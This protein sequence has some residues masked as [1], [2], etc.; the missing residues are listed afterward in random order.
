[1]FHSYLE[2]LKG[3]FAGRE[4][5]ITEENLQARIRGNYLMALSNKFGWLV[6]TT[7]NKSEMATGYATLY[8][9]M[10]G[11]FAVIKDVYKTDVYRI[12][13]W[14]N[15]WRGKEIIPENIFVKPPTAE[16]RPGQT[17][18]EKLPPYE[19]LDEILRLYIEEGLD[20]EEIAS[21]GFDRKTVLDVTEMIRKNE[22]KRKQAAIGV[23][24]STRAFGKDWRMPITNRFKEPL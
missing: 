9:D 6:L 24:I 13:R 1:M 12:G 8:G 3:V 7:G 21:K 2:T 20:P 10:A 16:L 19:V 15:S 23:K 4:P 11:G 18:Q 17:D 5:D 22:Y 14:Y